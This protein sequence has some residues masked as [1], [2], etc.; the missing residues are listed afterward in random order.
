MSNPSVKPSATPPAPADP[1]RQKRWRIAKMA[2]RVK[3]VAMLSFVAAIGVFFVAAP[4]GFSTT[5]VT[6]VVTL[7]VIG[8]VLLLPATIVGYA[9]NAAEREDRAAGR[10]T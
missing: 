7:M 6:V 8:S 4:G 5:S 2:K 3:R 1:V 9:A 10:I